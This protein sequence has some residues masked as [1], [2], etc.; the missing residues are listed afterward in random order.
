V[1]KG[2]LVVDFMNIAHR[3]RSGFVDG[4]FAVVYNF[5]RQFKALVSQFDPDKVYVAMEGHPKHRHAI[6]PIYKANRIVAEDDPK[7]ADLAKFFV[8]CDII[9]DLLQRRFPVSCIQHDDYEADDTIANVILNSSTSIDWII[10]SSDTDFIQLLDKRVGI[11]LYNPVRKEF[12]QSPEYDY[13][14]WK[15]LRGDLTDN[16]PG[17][18]GCGDKTATKLAMAV[19]TDYFSD[20]LRKDKRAEIFN[21]NLSLID[22]AEWSVE[23]MGKMNCSSP[24][25]DWN[26]VKE[27]LAGMA[28]K[29]II[30]D[31]SWKKFTDTFNKF[32][33]DNT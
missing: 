8:Q 7:A 24:A 4:E 23:E 12:I 11:Q 15:A 31:D 26:E 18:P 17:I 28:F 27:K 9:K 19:G 32:W 10:A 2:I 13:V 16:I 29:S 25:K 5:L 22:F 3:A 21:T 1:T 30:K 14:T 33:P 6:S 20:Y